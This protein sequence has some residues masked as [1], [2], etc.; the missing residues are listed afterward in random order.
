[1]SDS[2]SATRRGAGRLEP[3]PI[4]DSGHGPTPETDRELLRRLWLQ[5]KKPT[6]PNRAPRGEDDEGTG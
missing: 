4:L 5:Q 3:I 6:K 1:M 2:K